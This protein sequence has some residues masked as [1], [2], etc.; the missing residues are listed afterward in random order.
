MIIRVAAIEGSHWHSVYDATYLRH[1]AAMPDV[2]LVGV[3][4][5][6]AAVVKKRAAEGGKP[7]TFTDFRL[8]GQ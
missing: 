6:D 3:Q 7:P 2:A 1:L 4:D 8:L 5:G